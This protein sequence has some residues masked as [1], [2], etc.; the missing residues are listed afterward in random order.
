MAAVAGTAVTAALL[1]GCSGEDAPVIRVAPVGRATV[2]EVVEAPATVTAR[3]SAT[4]TAPATG[5]V[6]ALAVKDGQRV[7]A[8]QLVLRIDS[9]TA[10]SALRQAQD[11]DAQ[12]STAG[13]VR[14]P[15]T[16]LTSQ[17]HEADAAAAKAFA[18]ARE[19]ADAVPD[20]GVR[21][22]ALAAVA[23]AEAQYASAR[24]QAL[25]AVRRFDA[26]VGGLTAA[27]SSLSNAQRVQTKAAVAAAQRSV[28]ALVV[29][30]PIAGVAVLRTGRRGASTSGSAT[31]SQVPESLRGQASELLGGSGGAGSGAAVE[32]ALAVGTPVSAGDQLLSITDISSLSLT[33]EV[34]E[35]DV[36]L[37]RPGVTAD[38]ELDAVPDATYT[39]TVSTVDLN[40]TGSARGGVAYIVRLALGVG[41][42]AAGET[43]PAPR[44]GMS[45]VVDMR[46]RSAA[47]AIA[48]PAA[49]V[50][51]SG[52]GDAVW[53][54]R[55]GTARRRPVR[56]GAQGAAQVQVIEGL[57]VGE[58]VVVRGADRVAEGQQVP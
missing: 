20:A 18:A 48:V 15:R 54:V 34:D 50:F 42:T 13:A 29:R 8:G 1:V 6:A 52:R 10:R 41:R 2:T 26:G 28:D 17:Q 37:V 12:A 16:D 46:V 23:S 19:A 21:A 47:D 45:A 44:P 38:A 57:Q 56:L 31:L 3:A 14:V 7:K 27:L 55:A 43:A 24:A 25:D 5:R 36:L 39:A 4:L 58:R 51:R 30:A 49:A 40:P 53:V 35:T 33:A 22:R 9:P 32:G 11:A